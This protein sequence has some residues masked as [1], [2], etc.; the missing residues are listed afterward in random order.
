MQRR[1][2]EVKKP[3]I[4]IEGD[5]AHAKMSDEEAKAGPH[6]EEKQKAVEVADKK[7]AAESKAEVKITDEA[8][9]E[10]QEQVE[11][12]DEKSEA[13]VAKDNKE[14]ETESAKDD[15]EPEAES[16]VEVETKAEKEVEEV[17]T[18]KKATP[19]KKVKSQAVT[20]KQTD[21][22]LVTE[23]K[24]VERTRAK[25]AAELKTEKTEKA[26]KAKAAFESYFSAIEKGEDGN[27]ENQAIYR[28]LSSSQDELPSSI[29]QKMLIK[30]YMS[31]LKDFADSGCRIDKYIDV[32]VGKI[33]YKMF[34][35]RLI[36][37]KGEENYNSK[38]AGARAEKG[39]QFVEW[40]LKLGPPYPDDEKEVDEHGFPKI[41]HPLG[42]Q[43]TAIHS[44][45]LDS[46]H[47][48]A[49]EKIVIS[50]IFE[51]AEKTYKSKWEQV[52]EYI[53]AGVFE[54]NEIKKNVTLLTYED[55]KKKAA[56]TEENKRDGFQKALLEFKTFTAFYTYAEQWEKVREFTDD[57]KMD[58]G[59]YISL[60]EHAAK[61]PE[62]QRTELQKLLVQ[63]NTYEDLC[64]DIKNS[65]KL[66]YFKKFTVLVSDFFSIEKHLDINF[67][68]ESQLA[69]PG[70]EKTLIGSVT[71][72][73]NKYFNPITG[74]TCIFNSKTLPDFI[75]RNDL[76]NL[77]IYDPNRLLSLRP[78]FYEN[79][80]ILSRLGDI[81]EAIQLLN[82]QTN[83]LK[84]VGLEVGDKVEIVIEKLHIVLDRKNE[85]IANYAIPLAET[86]ELLAKINDKLTIG[87]VNNNFEHQ[88]NNIIAVLENHNQLALSQEENK[89]FE[90]YITKVIADVAKHKNITQEELMK[91]LDVDMQ[92]LDANFNALKELQS[93][94]KEIQNKNKTP[95]SDIQKKIIEIEN[96]LVEI[97]KTR[98]RFN[99]LK[100]HIRYNADP[101]IAIKTNKIVR[102]LR[103]LHSNFI[104]KKDQ[105]TANKEMVLYLII[106]TKKSIL[107]G[108][109]THEYLNKLY[110]DPKLQKYMLTEPAGKSKAK[111][112]RIE[113]ELAKENA[114]Q[115]KITSRNA[116][117]S[118]DIHHLTGEET[119]PYQIYREEQIAKIKNE[120][121]ACTDARARKK[122]N[123]YWVK[124]MQEAYKNEDQFTLSIVGDAL[125][126]QKKNEFF[127]KS[128]K[129]YLKLTKLNKKGT[130]YL[131][132]I[133]D[134]IKCKNYDF[135]P[136]PMVFTSHA[137]AIR[138]SLDQ[139]SQPDPEH[140]KVL[141]NFLKC[142]DHLNK[143]YVATTPKSSVA[144]KSD[145]PAEPVLTENKVEP[146]EQKKEKIITTP[147]TEEKSTVSKIPEARDKT[148]QDIELKK[149]AAQKAIFEN[150]TDNAHI[151][152]KM[153]EYLK[154]IKAGWETQ[155]AT[156][157]ANN[158][159]KKE[160]SERE[161]FLAQAIDSLE[162]K[163]PLALQDI[164]T[165][166]NTL[167]YNLGL[168]L[169]Q[170]SRICDCCAMSTAF[171]ENCARNI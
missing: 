88:Y 72:E 106:M 75:T 97:E 125:S 59:G 110:N 139:K 122:M 12:A 74:F 29:T 107:E 102:S 30:W 8:I 101:N 126:T 164:N 116:L 27:V 46:V 151:A 84:L 78:P 91:K 34:M 153:A 14:A 11:I 130:D 159:Q 17:K 7:S 48:D 86:S 15:K 140:Y 103:K 31:A 50:D 47:F 156:S 163:P 35:D 92:Q 81:S 169:K 22:K 128:R 79:K 49:Q 138:E 52:R 83:K 115:L 66:T 80:A 45:L 121:N 94:L 44:Y 37:G 21:A 51:S 32:I 20:R 67:N 1:D 42:K 9:E 85:K 39:K 160:I 55:L 100:E 135:I 132:N 54:K 143:N 25:T 112:K 40:L 123:S 64:K 53:T 146:V 70:A 145:K 133:H 61:I 108:N 13:V 76:L 60:K 120:I 162:T 148:P 166:L 105:N 99:L 111:I 38:S 152:A 6:A 157:S 56:S 131:D 95:N 65:D 36:L 165:T 41:Q 144:I 89:T 77:L 137:K 4:E 117:I 147:P 28:I 127:V 134:S 114:R 57:K 155:K 150:E 109:P 96:K 62:E 124:I 161:K 141:E 142:L 136:D 118:S 170:S 87:E 113:T 104:I 129:A 3:D 19:I 158:K 82:Q 26:A 119:P 16:K 149:S 23:V 24:I 10:K 71:L 93:Y 69:L 43:R 168:T 33:S 171:F 90:S 5:S 2:N 154:L 98:A 68:A 58:S 63:F 73:A 18:E 167:E